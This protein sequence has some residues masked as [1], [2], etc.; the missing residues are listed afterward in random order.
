MNEASDSGAKVDVD[1]KDA[2]REVQ[3]ANVGH[4][5]SLAG[6]S[7]GCPR[8]HGQKGADRGY[9]LVRQCRELDTFREKFEAG[10]SGRQSSLARELTIP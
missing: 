5:P 1:K 10:P 3:A 2:V 6:T 9:P 7:E 8:A 4:A